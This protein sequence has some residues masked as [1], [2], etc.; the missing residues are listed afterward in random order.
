MSRL[1]VSEKAI[2]PARGGDSFADGREIA[3][4]NQGDSSDRQR[5]SREVFRLPGLVIRLAGDKLV[6][7]LTG[8]AIGAALEPARRRELIDRLFSIITLESARILSRD[9]EIRLNFTATRISPQ[10]IV[11]A[12][13]KAT[14]GTRPQAIL[15]PHEEIISDDDAPAT[16]S[17]R[18]AGASFT[19]W[20]VDA[21]TPQIFRIAHPL[22]REEYIRR[23]VQDE[24]STLS[25]VILRSVPIPLAGRDALLVFGRPH[26]VDPALFAEVLD[27][28]LTQALAKGPNV[29]LPSVRDVLVNA[30]LVVAAITSFLFPP[31]GVANIA[32]TAT[33]SADYL[34]R[35]LASLREK[36][37]TLELLY[38]TIASLTIITYEFL[39]A[40]LMYWLMRY[41][42]RRTKQLYDSHY[43]RF[44]SRYRLRPR[45][46]WIDR[47]GTAIETRVEE[48]TSSSVVT[49]NAGDV[50]PGDGLIVEGTAKLDEAILT[51]TTDPVDKTSGKPIYAATRVVEGSVR[52]RIDELGHET[53]AGRL[54]RWHEK[55]HV[56]DATNAA[57]HLSAERT[58]SPVLLAS[59]IGALFGGLATAK[60]VIRPDYFSGPALAENLSRLA[61]VIRA[62]NEGILIT[63]GPDLGKLASPVS[64]VIDDTVQWAVPENGSI[65]YDA[66]LN[67][68]IEDAVYFSRGPEAR[69][70]ELAAR[71][72][73]P[74]VLR[75]VKG[76]S[77]KDYIARRQSE[78]A[79]VVYVGNCREERQ[80]AAQADLAITVA[81]LPFDNLDLSTSTLL[82]PDLLK[83]L[84]L[85]A[86]A[87][88]SVKESETAYKISAAPNVG[89]VAA[90]FL[91]ASPVLLSVLLTNLGTYAN[92]LRSETIL[93][94][95]SF[96]RP[97]GSEIRSA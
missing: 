75:E 31:L 4:L 33:L 84:Q 68:G 5:R 42:P 83:V 69:A 47:A 65:F 12:L 11:S 73:L 78:G 93:Q 36:K 2:V 10:E 30:N 52:I 67:Q 8:T 15:L 97:R 80:L 82:S 19:L 85:R 45:R 54:A 61:A 32:L 22:L 92:Y 56:R 34:P 60:A 17:V 51:G 43:S 57:A 16:F 13:A 90:G 35:A 76:Q 89:A 39:P 23:Q 26:R 29:P 70:A 86:I 44:L 40:A 72:G 48:L 96:S 21:L 50:V 64:L 87:L 46:V 9:G 53:A 95:T 94:L 27:P 28:I 91:F 74:S 25:D 59:A 20:E 6:A 37:M 24:L 3:V 41:W 49:L 79:T 66:A 55:A 14:G 62:A 63:G 88:D 71:L 7:T 81:Q 77:R 38:L 18:R 1:T 58:V